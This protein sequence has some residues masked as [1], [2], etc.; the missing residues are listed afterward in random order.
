P[1][2]Y[3]PRFSSHFSSDRCFCYSELHLLFVLHH[4]PAIPSNSIAVRPT[5]KQYCCPTYHQPVLLSD[6][7]S[8]SIAVRPTINQYCCPT[9]HQPVLLSDLPSTSIAVRPT[10]NQYCCPTY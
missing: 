9:Y 4:W 6:L 8:T 10:I 3:P 2:L 5:I 1:T 7:P